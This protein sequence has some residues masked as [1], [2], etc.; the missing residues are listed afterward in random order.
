VQLA[1]LLAQLVRAALDRSWLDRHRPDLVAEI[2]AEGVRAERE[3]ILGLETLAA[4]SKH[5]ERAVASMV[6]GESIEEARAGMDRYA[7]RRKRARDLE[8][9]ERAFSGPH[10]H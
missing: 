9:M 4:T 7:S 8:A 3:R 2:H 6:A 10:L 1:R 5:P